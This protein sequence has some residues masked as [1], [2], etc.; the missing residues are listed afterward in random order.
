M[1]TFELEIAET[2]RDSLHEDATR[3]NTIHESFKTVY[4]LKEY[5][6]K[7]Y[8]KMPKGRKK[9]YRDRKDAPSIVV[10]FLHSFWNKDYSHNSRK[11]YQT[12]WIE[13]YIQQTEISYFK[14]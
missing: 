13:F 9:I 2:G 7:R 3:F 11:W 1:Q 4:Q 5:L 14:L 6:I 12:D 10:G 8:G